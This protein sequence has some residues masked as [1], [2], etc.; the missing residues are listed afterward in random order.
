MKVRAVPGGNVGCWPWSLE[1]GVWTPPDQTS[2]VSSPS[3]RR[4]GAGGPGLPAGRPVPAAGGS[5]SSPACHRPGPSPLG[6]GSAPPHPWGASSW[7]LPNFQLS[8]G[9][10]LLSSWYPS[11]KGKK[12]NIKE[13]TW[14][15]HLRKKGKTCF[16]YLVRRNK[17]ILYDSEQMN[18]RP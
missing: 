15:S 9:H 10:H 11:T 13:L 3:W 16:H 14:I 2:S 7:L 8:P 17:S 1:L 18:L 5:W 6:A 12:I 4:S